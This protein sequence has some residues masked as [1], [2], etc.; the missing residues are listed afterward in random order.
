MFHA[1]RLVPHS[2]AILLGFASTV[3]AQRVLF[4]VHGAVAG[5][6]AAN[7]VVIGDWDGD[8]VQDFAVGAP[9]DG[10]AAFGAGAVRVHS[11]AN[12][13]VLATL[14]G[15]NYGDHFGEQVARIP[16]VNG[17]ATDELLVSAP[18]ADYKGDDSGSVYCFDGSSGTQLWRADGPMALV[19]F[20]TQVGGMGDVD[21]DGIGDVYVGGASD[22]QTSILSGTNGA[23]VG[24]AWTSFPFGR[25]VT[26]LDD[27]DGDGIREL[28]I[29]DRSYSLRSGHDLGIAYVVSP[30]WPVA[31]TLLTY[32]GASENQFF[33]EDVATLGDL[34]GDGVREYAI[35]SRL[36]DHGLAAM[37]EVYSG[38]TGLELAKIVSPDSTTLLTPQVADA[39]D[40]NGDGLRD[41]AISGTWTDAQGAPH[42][43]TFLFSG[44]T[45][46]LLDRIETADDAVVLAS[47]GDFD[48][49]GR[50][51]VIVGSLDAS[52]DGR[53]RVFGGAPLW[54][55]ATPSQPV[56]GATLELS[57]REGAP[58]QPTVLVVEAVDGA[59][60]FV[61]LA[62]LATF[63]PLGGRRISATVPAGLAG[64]DATLRAFAHDASNRL[65]RSDP[66]DVEFR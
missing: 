60:T 9:R 49:D 10:T 28:L 66:Q 19:R 32:L 50:D 24:F 64:H 26:A 47:A 56:A 13:R 6:G 44:K 35:A 27:I 62:G 59:P 40:V 29:G 7:G 61:V 43:A 34:D 30:T 14:L 63:G 23:D 53:V 15:A 2:I 25:A 65:I 22:G 33:G 36:D 1:L 54:Q 51:D 39:G 45:F 17:N 57:T 31:T 46:L 5:G 16:D 55:D 58:G 52:Y 20:G 8:G 42:A 12:G 18:A 37:V 48:G 21:G 11:G 4:D 38:A 3:H 41:L